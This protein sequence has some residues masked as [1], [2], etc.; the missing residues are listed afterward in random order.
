M[1]PADIDAAMEIAAKTS[2][3]PRWERAAYISAIEE[4][5]Q[6]KRV[7]L[8]AER[9]GGLAGFAVAGVLPGEEAELESIVTALPHQRRGV[10]RQLFAVLKAELRRQAVREV[11]LEVRE[12]NHSAQDFYRFLGFREEARR[13]GYY[14][15]PV[16]DAVLMKLRLR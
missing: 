5:S 7:A 2:H 12:A 11:M 16:E 6:P 4:R 1:E 15:E 9:D 3:A 10:G 8:I 13:R 14:S